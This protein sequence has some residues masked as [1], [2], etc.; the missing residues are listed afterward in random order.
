MMV[1][2]DGSIY[3]AP[4][5]KKIII[6]RKGNSVAKNGMVPVD[7]SDGDIISNKEL[8]KGAKTSFHASGIINSIDSR[9]YRNSLRNISEQEELCSVL[10]Q[11]PDKFDNIAFDKQQNRDILTKTPIEE[12][13]PLLARVFVSAI[14][15]TEPIFDNIVRNQ[16]N[17]ILRYT[18][19]KD[20]VDF[21]VQINLGCIGKGDWP[22]Y[23]YILY[24]TNETANNGKL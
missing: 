12:K 13:S 6:I 21:D 23:T 5:K 2:N 9:S 1:G 15:K 8:Y 4:R 22:P 17:I 18:G 7:Y 11:H 20:C 10:F 19:L 14:E 24:P 3:I 16:I